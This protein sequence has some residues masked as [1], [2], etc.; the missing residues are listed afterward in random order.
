MADNVNNPDHY[1]ELDI[2]FHLAIA[3]AS[4]NEMLKIV[5]NSIQLSTKAMIVKGLSIREE[6]EDLQ[7]VQTIHEEIVQA[8]TENNREEAKSAMLKHFDNILFTMGSIND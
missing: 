3:R 7:A 5:M 4:R 2:E 8:I 6:D 1:A